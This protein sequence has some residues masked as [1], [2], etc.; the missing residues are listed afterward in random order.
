MDSLQQSISQLSETPFPMCVRKCIDVLRG[1]PTYL[2]P[3][4]IGNLVNRYIF[5]MIQDEDSLW[6]KQTDSLQDLQALHIIAEALN[7]ER[8][9]A[10]GH[11]I[12]TSL[13]SL[14]N[15]NQRT[16]H[17]N[18]YFLQDS[19]VGSSNEFWIKHLLDHEEKPGNWPQHVLAMLTSFTMSANYIRVLWIIGDW[20]AQQLQT[21]KS[22]EF[23]FVIDLIADQ[24]IVDHILLSEGKS[25]K[26]DDS[27]CCS[28]SFQNLMVTSPVLANLIAPVLERWGQYSQIKDVWSINRSAT[29]TSDVNVAISKVIQEISLF[30]ASENGNQLVKRLEELNFADCTDNE[31]INKVIEML[32]K[33]KVE[34]SAV[35]LRRIVPIKFQ[36]DHQVQF[37]RLCQCM[38]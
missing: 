18:N 8:A 27:R 25:Q 37:Q 5:F 16:K 38:K 21:S 6:S 13:F 32:I 30:P 33:S 15:I 23:S 19:K 9:T 1:F 28:P 10:M 36:L 24:L 14:S 31:T 3:N 35:V 22:M 29:N 34:L 12:L 26:Q 7:D 2:S 17:C 11:F 4:E 20:L